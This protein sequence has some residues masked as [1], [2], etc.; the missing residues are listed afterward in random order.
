MDKNREPVSKKDLL[1]WKLIKITASEAA[2]RRQCSIGVIRR[3]EKLYQVELYRNRKYKAA[4]VDTV[5]LDD[6][7]RCIAA[8]MN[9]RQ[10][11][12]ALNKPYHNV[13]NVCY[14][15]GLQIRKSQR[16]EYQSID[17]DFVPLDSYGK[18]SLMYKV[19]DDVKA[20]I[21]GKWR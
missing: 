1:E 9:M 18:E 4:V 10:I 8:N 15:N 21:T 20:I 13:K 19:S 2:R 17:Y 11:C 5:L 7:K 12:M 14:Q 6:I 16:G 3:A